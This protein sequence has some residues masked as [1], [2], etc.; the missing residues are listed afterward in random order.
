MQATLQRALQDFFMSKTVIPAQLPYS[1]CEQQS[2]I[3]VYLLDTF[4]NELKSI[5]LE[6]DICRT[7]LLSL[8][9]FLSMFLSTNTIVH[10]FAMKK[11][12]NPIAMHIFC[13]HLKLYTFHSQSHRAYPTFGENHKKI[14]LP[15]YR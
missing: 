8:K 15:I 1:F 6:R 13:P 12:G 7:D 11:P 2:S 9:L 3:Y 4:S 14:Y 10:F 5:L